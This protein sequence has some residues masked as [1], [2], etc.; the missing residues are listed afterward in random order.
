MEDI[1]ATGETDGQPAGEALVITAPAK[2]VVVN[3]WYVTVDEIAFA[4][5]AHD[6]P[7]NTSPASDR[8]TTAVDGCRIEFK[9]KGSI[10]IPGLTVEGLGSLINNAPF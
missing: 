6:H 10:F 3:G 5:N 1:T 7:Y 9:R 8:I 2:A 4:R